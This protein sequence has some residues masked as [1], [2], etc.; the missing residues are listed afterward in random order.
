MET[1][2]L[3]SARKKDISI[4]EKAAEAAKGQYKEIS[5]RS[6]EYTLHD[7]LSDDM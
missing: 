3:I 2:I 5:G 6:F 1:S 7:N 4:V